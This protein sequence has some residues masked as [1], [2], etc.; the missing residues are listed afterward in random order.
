MNFMFIVK[1]HYVYKGRMKGS[2]FCNLFK[3]MIK[4]TS[5]FRLGI[6][7]ITHMYSDELNFIRSRSTQRAY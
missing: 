6:Q 2:F 1:R 5:R 7:Q 3:L 4:G